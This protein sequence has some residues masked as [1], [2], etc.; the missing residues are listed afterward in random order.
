MSFGEGWGERIKEGINFHK[1]PNNIKKVYEYKYVQINIE[2]LTSS[3]KEN[4]KM[5]N[6]NKKNLYRYKLLPLILGFENSNKLFQK[7]DQA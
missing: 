4:E 7:S 1:F 5:A 2:E 3:K 6:R